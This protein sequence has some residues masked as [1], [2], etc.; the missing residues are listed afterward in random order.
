MIRRILAGAAI[1]GVALGICAGAA[2]ADVGPHV[3]NTGQNILGQ[4]SVIDDVSVL[5]NVLNDSVKHIDL[6]TVG[7]FQDV[8]LNL[9]ANVEDS[10]GKK[11]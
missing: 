10:K 8:G 4:F 1:V 3:S 7:H 5:N 9:L 6:G 2:S 11:Y